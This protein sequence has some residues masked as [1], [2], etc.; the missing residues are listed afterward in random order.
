MRRAVID[1]GTNTVKLL[2]ADVQDGVVKPVFSTDRTTRLGEGLDKTRQ[3]SAPAIARTLQAIQDFLGEAETR[4]AETVTALTTS[5]ARDAGN[6]DE[7]LA[8]VRDRCGL[9]LELIS[10]EREAELIFRGVSSDPAW[11]EKPILVMDVGGGSAEFIQG[12]RGKIER[13]QTRPLGAVRMTEQFGEERLPELVAHLRTEL[14]AALRGYNLHDRQMIA[15]GGTITTLAQVEQAKS[16]RAVLTQQ[17]LRALV[18][19]LHA[20]PLA[21]RRSVPHLPPERAD[22]IVAGGMVFITA[23]EILRAAELTVSVRNLRYG[24]LLTDGCY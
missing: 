17:N 19:R 8:N 5:A 22:I 4:D 12:C 3:L 2:V 10:G 15:T 13:A 1:V 23:M 21:E 9:E 18:S 11:S 14:H 20:L 7:F 6:R 24:A 16:D